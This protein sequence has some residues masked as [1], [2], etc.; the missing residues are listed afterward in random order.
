M[1][2]RN[3]PVNGVMLQ[4]KRSQFEDLLNV[5]DGER[6]TGPGWI[7]LFCKTY[8]IKECQKHGES[9]SVD[10]KAVANEQVQ[11]QGLLS[12]YSRKDTFNFDET[13]FNTFAPPDC[14]LSTKVMGGKK[15]EKFQIMMGLAC[16]AN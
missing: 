8:I 4:A 14:E 13:S 11:M 16:N 9:A 10:L 12:H 1:E 3:E 5:A 15:K 7:P 2:A 6:L